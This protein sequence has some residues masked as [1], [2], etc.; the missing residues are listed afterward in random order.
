VRWLTVTVR[1]PSM[2]PTLYDGDRVL[3]RRGARV[4]PGDLVLGRFAGVDRLVVKRAV[5]PC[6]DGGAGA[7][8]VAS[9]NPYAGGDSE[10]HGPAV[11]LARVRWRYRPPLRRGRWGQR[12]RA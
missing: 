5:R 2:V 8:W 10:V 3:A 7:W 1:G 12:P 11:V 4:R 6:P 9:D